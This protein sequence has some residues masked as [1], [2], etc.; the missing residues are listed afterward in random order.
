MRED[1]KGEMKITVKLFATLRVGR[2]KI[3]EMEYDESIT[4]GQL[5]KLLGISEND[6]GIMFIN[7]HHTGLDTELREGDT[8]SIFPLVG[9]G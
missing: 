6:L 3:K 5:V 4:V 2:F 7:G 9:G 1:V 8:I